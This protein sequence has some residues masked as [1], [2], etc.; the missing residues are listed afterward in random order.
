M[1]KQKRNSFE[2]II[3]IA[4]LVISCAR[5]PHEVSE[6]LELT[7]KNKEGYRNLLDHYKKTD[8]RKYKAACFLISN[9]PYHESKQRISLDSAYFEYFRMTDSVYQTEFAGYQPF[10]NL[11]EYKPRSLDSLRH[12]MAER[13]KHLPQPVVTEGCPDIESI[14]PAFLEDNIG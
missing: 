11:P 13:Y 9:M 5:Y 10:E 4:L 6:A 7:G 1:N 12:L 14:S 8:K 3:I 2:V